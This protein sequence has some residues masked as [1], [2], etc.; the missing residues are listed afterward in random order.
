M[1][2][3]VILVAG[4]VAAAGAPRLLQKEPAPS[5]P[6]QLAAAS[7]TASDGRF[8]PTCGEDKVVDIRPDP[9]WVS[10]SFKNDACEAPSLP[11]VKNGA[12]AT[13]EE[14]VAAMAGQKAYDTAALHFEKCVS[15]FVAAR[16]TDGTGSFPESRAIIEN[17]RILASQRRRQSVATQVRVAI[18]AFNRYGSDCPD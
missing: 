14:I 10:A 8:A 1:W 16:R 6:A 3:K 18:N 4:V 7:K 2:I 11:V 12:T 15:D 13:R 17:H 9:A 5:E